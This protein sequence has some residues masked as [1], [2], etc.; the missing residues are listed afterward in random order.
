MLHAEP[1]WFSDLRIFSLYIRA[2]IEDQD[3][4]GLEKAPE[5]LCVEQILKSEN[6][7][8]KSPNPQIT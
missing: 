1:L 6:Q 2:S 5:G 3:Y 7:I 8:I 4:N